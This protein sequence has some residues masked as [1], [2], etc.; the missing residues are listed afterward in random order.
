[1]IKGLQDF[2]IEYVCHKIRN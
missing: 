2:Y 1:M